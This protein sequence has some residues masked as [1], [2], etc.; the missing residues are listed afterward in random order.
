MLKIIKMTPEVP[1]CTNL[2]A[3]IHQTEMS[4][5]RKKLHNLNNLSKLRHLKYNVIKKYLLL[6]VIFSKFSYGCTLDIH[7]LDLSQ[8]GEF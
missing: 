1:D 4:Y 8:Y 6:L 7:G 2:N 3:Y 5:V